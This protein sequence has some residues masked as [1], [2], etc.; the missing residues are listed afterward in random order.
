MSLQ[1]VLMKRLGYNRYVSQGGDHGSVISDAMAR[2]A[3]KGLLGIHLTMPATVPAN[4][5]KAINSGEPFR[6]AARA[7]HAQRSQA[8]A[9]ARRAFLRGTGPAAAG[10]PGIAS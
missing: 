6:A 4:L 9:G 10:R 3:P 2:Q 1:T 7:R 8:G 5:A